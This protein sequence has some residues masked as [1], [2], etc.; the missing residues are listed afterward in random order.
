MVVKDGDEPRAKAPDRSNAFKLE[1]FGGSGYWE[2]LQRD[3]SSSNSSSSSSSD[4]YSM[5][6]NSSESNSNSNRINESSEI[7]NTVHSF[8]VPLRTCSKGE[9]DPSAARVLGGSV[10]ITDHCLPTFSTSIPTPRLD[11][12]CQSS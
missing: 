11:L 5:R 6:S 7:S 8:T 4:R 10:Q 2:S 1:S 9:C 12:E 3:S